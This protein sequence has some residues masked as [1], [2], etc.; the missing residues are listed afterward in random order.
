MAADEPAHG[1]R[2]AA[3]LAEQP[4]AVLRMPPNDSE[5]R[6]RGLAA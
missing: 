5:L 4:I 6:C 1:L 3:E 2:E